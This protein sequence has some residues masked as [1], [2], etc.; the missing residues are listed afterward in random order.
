[1]RLPSGEPLGWW[2]SWQRQKF[3]RGTLKK[4]QIIA[5]NS[6]RFPWESLYR[7]SDGTR[8]VSLEWKQAF[9]ELRSF[10]REHPTAWPARSLLLSN[11]FALGTWCWRQRLAYKEKRLSSQRTQLLESIDFPWV[12]PMPKTRRGRKGV[13][14]NTARG[15]HAKNWK[16]AFKRLCKYRKRFPADWPVFRAEFPKG[17]LLGTWCAY[18][19]RHKARGTL[20]KKRIQ[21]LEVIDFPWI[22]GRKTS[23]GPQT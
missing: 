22:V 20:S 11:D 19:R 10:R 21:A 4:E 9:K 2:C 18:Q 23:R 7:R 13:K 1:M 3:Q 5:L 6:I 16:K 8:P 17:K 12:A 15:K 14:K